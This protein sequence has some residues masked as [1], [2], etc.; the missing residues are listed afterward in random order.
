MFWD[1]VISGMKSLLSWFLFP[2][3]FANSSV[4]PLPVIGSIPDRR[5]VP[6]LPV[7]LANVVLAVK[8]ALS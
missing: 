1:L 5:T 6:G 8:V 3:L 4:L 2:L 7:P